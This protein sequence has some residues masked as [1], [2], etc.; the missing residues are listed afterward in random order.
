MDEFIKLIEESITLKDENLVITPD[1]E[2]T[3][4]VGITSLDMMIV[5]L[6]IERKYNKNLTM[7]NLMKAKTVADLYALVA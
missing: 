2:L 4:D 6:A 1:M 5:V 3:A 7:E